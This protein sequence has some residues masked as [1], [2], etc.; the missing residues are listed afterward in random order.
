MIR[1][2]MAIG[3]INN[4]PLIPVPAGQRQVPAQPGGVEGRRNADQSLDP[5]TSR[6]AQEL[7]STDPN[8]GQ[9]TPQRQRAIPLEEVSVDLPR[10]SI[11]DITV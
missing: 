7:S 10:G 9:R 1:V 4:V 5:A 3:P 2:G 6:F 11:L 8:A